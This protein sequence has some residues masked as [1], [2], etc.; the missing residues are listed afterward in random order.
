[1]DVGGWIFIKGFKN[2]MILVDVVVFIEG[3]LV[4]SYKSIVGW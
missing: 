1:M 3:Y 4:I 2:G